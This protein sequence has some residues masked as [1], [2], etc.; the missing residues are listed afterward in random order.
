[1]SKDAR[2]LLVD[3]SQVDIELGL[4]AFHKAGFHSV[5]GVVRGT[6]CYLDY[7]FKRTP[8]TDESSLPGSRFARS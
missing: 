5:H 2:I 3:D 4:Q 6:G 8:N 1:M 7:L